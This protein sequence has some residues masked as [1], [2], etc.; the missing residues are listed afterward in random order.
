[1][2]TKQYEFADITLLVDG[3]DITGVRSIKFSEK[4]ER[5]ALYAKGRYPHSVQSGNVAY[6]GEIGLTQNELELLIAK[7]KGS[8]L[9]LKMDAVIT[10][11][12]P[13]NGDTLI[14]DKMLGI[15]FTESAKELKQGDKFMDVKLPFIGLRLLQQVA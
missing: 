9:N 13:S 5:E 14:T 12:N 6:E 2:D 10:Y 3:V 7:G 8:I 11:G 1:M 15:H 4:I